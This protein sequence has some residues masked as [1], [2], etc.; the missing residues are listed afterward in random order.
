MLDK[1]VKGLFEVVNEDAELFEISA[2][3]AFDL[4]GKVENPITPFI[5]LLHAYVRSLYPKGI[6]NCLTN[7]RKLLGI[8]QYY[9]EIQRSMGLNIQEVNLLENWQDSY[10]F[11]FLMRLISDSSGIKDSWSSAM[12]VFIQRII[13]EK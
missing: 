11:T 7:S 6:K 12:D 3:K 5:Q 2:R 13:E 10:G 8:F 1:E 4:L 9:V